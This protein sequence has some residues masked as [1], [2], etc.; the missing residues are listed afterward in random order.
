[1]DVTVGL[2][3]SVEVKAG[4]KIALSVEFLDTVVKAEVSAQ[5]GV[6]VKGEA[7]LAYHGGN[8]ESIHSCALCVDA[9]FNAFA[10]GKVELKY[11]ICDALSGTPV[12]VTLFDIRWHIIDAYFSLINSSDSMFGGSPKMGWGECPNKK[13]RTSF[14]V[15]DEN[16]AYVDAGISITGREDTTADKSTESGE[17]IYLYPGKYLATSKVGNANIN[18]RFTVK[19][20]AQEVLL[21]KANAD[22]YVGGKVTSAADPSV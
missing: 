6:E 2:E 10:E 15:Q 18:K 20:Q 16:G 3:G 13:Y 7:D 5:G 19:N 14:E 9:E 22:G 1:M 8:G 17:T 4:P 12:D 21:S 11:E